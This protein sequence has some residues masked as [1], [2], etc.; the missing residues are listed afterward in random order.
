MCSLIVGT[1]YQHAV[2]RLQVTLR[3][4]DTLR[5]LDAIVSG[6]I[7]FTPYPNQKRATPIPAVPSRGSTPF[8]LTPKDAR[9]SPLSVPYQGSSKDYSTFGLPNSLPLFALPMPEI[10][11]MTASLLQD[12]P[13]AFVCDLFQ[14]DSTCMYSRD[15]VR[16]RADVYPWGVS[17]D[18][19]NIATAMLRPALNIEV[20]V[21]CVPTERHNC[22]TTSGDDAAASTMP[23]G[24]SSQRIAKVLQQPAGSLIGITNQQQHHMDIHNADDAEVSVS[25]SAER[26]AQAAAADVFLGTAPIGAAPPSLPL[27]YNYLS[28][29]GLY[30]V[31]G[32]YTSD[33]VAPVLGGMYRY[34]L[35]FMPPL[36]LGDA[37]AGRKQAPAY[38]VDVASA[39]MFVRRPVVTPAGG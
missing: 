3:L 29:G 39:V 7:T 27:S 33:P 18:W 14:D 23:G 10:D 22:T 35:R 9:L 2:K 31:N 20:E 1:A 13:P 6:Y 34:R 28:F 17:P 36:A 15:T 25:V 19:I 16:V 26:S 37:A 4:P 5:Q 32:N 24:V 38:V 30:Y 8:P 21:W 11:P 12:R